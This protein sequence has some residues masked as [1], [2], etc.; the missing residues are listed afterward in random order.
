LALPRIV[1]CLLENNQ[2]E[3]V[4]ALPAILHSYMGSDSI[5]LET[6]K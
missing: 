2:K 6:G 3:N 5:K 1:A 4:I